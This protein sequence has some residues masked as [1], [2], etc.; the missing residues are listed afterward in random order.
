MT[1]AARAQAHTALFYAAMFGALGAHLPF[2]PVWLTAWGLSPQEAG[3]FL[4]LSF[5]ARISAG[6]LIP[7]LADRSGRRRITMAAL[8]IAGALV[9][10]AHAAIGTRAALLAATVISGGLISATMP[11]GEALGSGAATR[12]GFSYALPRA[13]G[14]LGFLIANFAVGA[15][16]ARL[17]P[18]AALWWIV[19][20]LAAA[21]ALALRHPGGA[22]QDRAPPNFAEI[23]RLILHPIFALFLLAGTMTMSSHAVY[24]TYSSVR[25][26]SLGIGPQTI[27]ALWAFSVAV[28]VVFMLTLGRRLIG[29]I[30]PLGALMLA[31]A[32][33]VVRWGLMAFDPVL[34]LLWPL[35][36]LH[37]L[38]FAAGHLGCIAFI[39]AAVPERLNASAQGAFMG[40]AA[41]ILTVAAMALAAW[42]YPSLGGGVYWIAAAMSAA[43]LALTLTLRRRWA[44][45]CL[46]FHAPSRSPG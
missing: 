22:K 9:F 20:L 25:W 31:A 2:W 21:A 35:Q 23:G 34:P 8:A 28:E 26:Q 44:G 11:L 3:F 36:A 33:G 7:V 30:G 5:V 29:W 38:T 13:L 32:G 24:Y 40:L 14:S 18:D 41:G 39:A 27:G 19:V 4:S 12:F 37:V 46:S 1:R 43:G 6:L 17:G 16:M 10:A 42:A 45:A 15:L